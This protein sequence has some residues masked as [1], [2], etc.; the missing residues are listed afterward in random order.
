MASLW[1]AI[2]RSQQDGNVVKPAAPGGPTN[3]L[4]QMD[5]LTDAY[6][7]ELRS[8]FSGCNITWRRFDG[9]PYS[10]GGLA[11]TLYP[12]IIAARE[13]LDTAPAEAKTLALHIHSDAPGAG[14]PSL[15]HVGGRW[16]PVGTHSKLLLS[17]ICDAIAPVFST[18]RILLLDGAGYAFSTLF[19]DTDHVAAIVEHGDHTVLADNVTLHT[20]PR[21]IARASLGAIVAYYGL[22]APVFPLPPEPPTENPTI[23]PKAAAA[24]DA[25]L[26]ANPAL[27][28]GRSGPGLYFTDRAG[29]VVR[30][31]TK[32]AVLFWRRTT[33][34]VGVID[35]TKPPAL[36]PAAVLDELDKAEA[37]IA[38]AKMLV[39]GGK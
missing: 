12:N 27:G 29:D 22:P 37:G 20:R 9:L 5:A 11:A 17:D 8:A 14:Q 23:D 26:A 18:T 28:T 21:D 6:V 1:M 39:V 32:G 3:E 38:A 30:K 25:I 13:W 4:D 31:T 16:D 35:W 2:V 36:N 34:A 19:A 33:G 10:E 24:I 15:S 7:A